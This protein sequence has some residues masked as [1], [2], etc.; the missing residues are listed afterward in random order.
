METNNNNL[1]VTPITTAETE[2]LSKV[3]GVL[4]NVSEEVLKE[5]ESKEKYGILLM[6]FADKDAII[7]LINSNL[8]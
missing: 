5:V 4:N 3:F 6:D 7:K 8:K 2:Y 1:D